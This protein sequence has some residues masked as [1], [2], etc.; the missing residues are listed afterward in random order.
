MDHEI[1]VLL[2][3]V[4]D[5]LPFSDAI[6]NFNIL[7]NIFFSI[8]IALFTKMYFKRSKRVTLSNLLLFSFLS[9]ATNEDIF[10]RLK[11]SARLKGKKNR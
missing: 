8:S 6:E 4:F 10:S 9:F 2:S 1:P 7:L 11:V 5:R 3:E